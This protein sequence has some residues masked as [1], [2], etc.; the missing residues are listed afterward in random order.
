MGLV[1]L[2]AAA[3]DTTVP[4]VSGM[5]ITSMPASG[6]AYGMGETI[7]SLS[8][9]CATHLTDGPG[10]RAGHAAVE[11]IGTHRRTAAGFFPA[12]AQVQRHQPDNLVLV[13]KECEWHFT[14]D[15]HQARL[16]QLRYGY[17]NS[18]Y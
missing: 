6:K 1:A 15:N 18:H 16:L 5:A 13:L 2:H 10:L 7:N 14:G 17:Q 11:I 3:Q 4:T 9:E 12:S 8:P